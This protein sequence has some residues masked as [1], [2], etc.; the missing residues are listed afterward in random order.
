MS[1]EMK[2]NFKK[3]KNL[4]SMQ[5]EELLQ[6]IKYEL[7]HREIS[8]RQ[9]CKDCGLGYNYI[10]NLMNGNV[11][12]SGTSFERLAL[13]AEYLGFQLSYSLHPIRIATK[14]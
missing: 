13:M 7:F 9:M 6:H 5:P 12:I 11:P 4:A 3:A 1:A 2:Q 8:I 14:K 10:I